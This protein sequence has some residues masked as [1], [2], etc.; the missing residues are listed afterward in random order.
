MRR[1]IQFFRVGVADSLDRMI[2]A[3]AQRFNFAPNEILA[4]PMHELHYWYRG[5]EALVKEENEY[6]AALMGGKKKK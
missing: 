2:W 5:H 4:L 1:V 6:T 3:I